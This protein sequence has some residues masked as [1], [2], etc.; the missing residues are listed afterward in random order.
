MSPAA[1]S[2][3]T[4]ASS[5]GAPL[6]IAV[7][8]PLLER[9]PRW[10]V[11]RVSDRRGRR[12]CVSLGQPHERE[13]GLRIPAGAMSSQKGL[14]GAFDV[15]RA[16][17][18]PPELAQRPSHLAPQVGAQFLACAERLCL[19]LAARATQP[20]DFR[21]VDP[22]AP[23]QAADGIRLAPPLHR[24]GPLLGDVVLGEA[25]QRA[26]EL[27]VDDPGRER[28]EVPGHRCHPNLIEQR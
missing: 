4:C 17:S 1:I 12:G 8:R 27:A 20:E 22:A 26:D 18:D 14:L 5:S 28:I 16:K 7:G 23:V 9:H 11:E 24:L 2:I 3:S 15:S 10:L 21:A 19:C 13:T 6:Q 25:L